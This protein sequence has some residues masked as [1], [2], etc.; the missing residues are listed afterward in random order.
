MRKNVKITGLIFIA[1]IG[2]AAISISSGAFTMNSTYR[3]DR[4]FGPVIN[5]INTVSGGDISNR[6]LSLIGGLALYTVHCMNIPTFEYRGNVRSI[7]ANYRRTTKI[8]E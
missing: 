7:S 6:P 1:I 5:I 8:A 3:A 4:S 2:L